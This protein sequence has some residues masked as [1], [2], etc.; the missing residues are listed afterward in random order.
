M[1]CTPLISEIFTHTVLRSAECF[2][3]ERFGA[4]AVNTVVR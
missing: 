3:I 2:T 1:R 4:G